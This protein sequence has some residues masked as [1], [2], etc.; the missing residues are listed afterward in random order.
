[1]ILRTKHASK[2]D[3][4]F[5]SLCDPIDDIRISGMILIGDN[6][7]NRNVPESYEM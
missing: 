3:R 6:V 4:N 2:L 1:M 5:K 7:I